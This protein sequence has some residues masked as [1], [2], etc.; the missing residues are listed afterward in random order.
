MEF[1]IKTE[2]RFPATEIRPLTDAEIDC[3]E[4]GVSHGLGRVATAV[5][6]LVARL[7]NTVT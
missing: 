3:V 5:I 4:G 7:T 6:N 1:A 2:E